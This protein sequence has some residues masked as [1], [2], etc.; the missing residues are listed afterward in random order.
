MRFAYTFLLIPLMSGCS[1]YGEPS[2][3][4][5]AGA[6]ITVVDEGKDFSEVEL[7]DGRIAHVRNSLLKQRSQADGTEQGSYTHVLSAGG[8]LYDG[9]PPEKQPVDSPRAQTEIML[10]HMALNALF[11]TEQS[12]REVIAPLN[13]VPT[14]EGE[15]CWPAYMCTNSSCPGED[16]GNNGRPFLFINPRPGTENWCP[17][18]LMIRNQS[19][20]S[21]ND[22]MRFR[23]YVV[24]YELPEARRR[25]REL[26][27]ERK[28]RY[29]TDR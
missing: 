7:A 12:K 21:G 10:E 1:N 28:R 9:G 15:T 2:G 8:T 17:E 11:L 19:S 27:A 18:C 4:V 6:Q 29:G 3:T 14:F 22:R 13:S 26:D 16:K 23:G 20:E 24:P 25:A 5:D